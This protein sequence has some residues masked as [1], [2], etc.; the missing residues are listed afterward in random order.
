MSAGLANSLR[1]MVERFE[2]AGIPFMLAG[3]FASTFHGHPRT[4]QDIDIVIDPTLDAL[5]RFVDALPPDRSY[6]DRTAAIDAF[7]QR[8]MFNVI[9]LE[10]GWKVD[11]ILRKNRPYSRSEF[12]R[13]EAVEWMGVRLFVV[14]AEDVVLSKLEWSQLCG[15]SERQMRDVAGV[16]ETRRGKLDVEYIESWLDALGVRALW[17]VANNNTPG[18]GAPSS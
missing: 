11:L 17:E 18:S 1:S 13:R 3:S 8:D 12:E 7:H 16:I 4:T 10:T 15:G 6:A 2:A 5:L 14:T 9:D